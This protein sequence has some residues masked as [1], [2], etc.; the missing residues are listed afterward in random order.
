MSRLIKLGES[1]A[2]LLERMNCKVESEG[3]LVAIHFGNTVVRMGYNEALQL[4]QWMRVRA[5]QSKRYAGD[6]SQHLSVVGVLEG[7]KA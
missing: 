4:S 6:F 3:E 5:K 1:P 7:I 2:P